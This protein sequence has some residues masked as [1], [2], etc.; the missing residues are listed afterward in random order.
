MG[1]FVTFM[2]DWLSNMAASY[3]KGDIFV[4]MAKQISVCV[5]IVLEISQLS[6]KLFHFVFLIGIH[7]F[8]AC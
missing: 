3:V 7:E 2:A 1:N 5:Y 6:I 4:V 8:I